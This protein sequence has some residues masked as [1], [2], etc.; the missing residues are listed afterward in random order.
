MGEIYCR[1]PAC[2]TVQF[3][4][5]QLC[6]EAPKVTS[7][8]PWT[9]FVPE[10]KELD[11]IEQLNHQ[12][13]WSWFRTDVHTHAI[14]LE[15]CIP[16]D[17]QSP[18][19]MFSLSRPSA[20]PPRSPASLPL[21]VL[22]GGGQM[23]SR[24]KKQKGLQS[25]IILKFNVLEHFFF[26]ICYFKHTLWFNDSFGEFSLWLGLGA[27]RTACLIFFSSYNQYFILD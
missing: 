17:T 8:L 5:F 27:L 2:A 14:S 12:G 26:Q 22:G 19:A 16:R 21:D 24:P 13:L 23:L 25:E 9:L 4:A 1:V 7:R 20:S 11:T 6:G 3:F 15:H 10:C 18:D